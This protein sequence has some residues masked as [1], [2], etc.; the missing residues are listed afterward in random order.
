[1]TIFQNF[2]P[3]IQ[4]GGTKMVLKPNWN[5]FNKVQTDNH[6][7]RKNVATNEN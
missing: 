7:L 5:M 2:A 6:N 4:T 1:M 3:R